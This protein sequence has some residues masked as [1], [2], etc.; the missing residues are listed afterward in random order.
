M[1]L[2]LCCKLYPCEL[3]SVKGECTLHICTHRLYLSNKKLD[4]TEMSI[5][6]PHQTIQRVFSLN[7][8]FTKFYFISTVFVHKVLFSLFFVVVAEISLDTKDR[9]YQL[10]S[11]EFWKSWFRIG[12][13]SMMSCF[14][15]VFFVLLSFDSQISKIKHKTEPYMQINWAFAYEFICTEHTREAHA[16]IA[17]AAAMTVA[18]PT[19]TTR[20]RAIKSG[21]WNNTIDFQI[22]T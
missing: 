4:K 11:V 19:M 22:N 1:T 3:E 20:E 8:K 16:T 5:S 9:A 14:L 13:F 17:A 15:C 6:N 12:T 7:T 2:W 10:W 18:V 21:E